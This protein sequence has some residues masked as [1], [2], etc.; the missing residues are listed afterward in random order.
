MFTCYPYWTLFMSICYLTQ[1][2]HIFWYIH[3]RLCMWYTLYTIFAHLYIHTWTHKCTQILNF[4]TQHMIFLLH[5]FVKSGDLWRYVL[6]YSCFCEGLPPSPSVCSFLTVGATVTPGTLP[7][8]L[9]YPLWI[10]W[11][12]LSQVRALPSERPLVTSEQPKQRHRHLQY[13]LTYRIV[14]L[15]CLGR[16][17]VNI[18][19]KDGSVLGRANR[20]AMMVDL[21]CLSMLER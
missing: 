14:F 13:I 1:V 3:I 15:G 20:W 8:C 11:S 2:I 12:R 6:K 18:S 19:E 4:M 17:K 7:L 16:R 5:S 10:L 9:L 21:A